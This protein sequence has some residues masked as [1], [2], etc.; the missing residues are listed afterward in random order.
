[1][2]TSGDF[3]IIG[4]GAI[5]K[6]L[7]RSFPHAK[8][9]IRPDFDIRDT[10][11]DMPY[12]PKG[13]AVICAAITGV[14]MC[15]AYPDWSRAVNVEAT[16]ALAEHLAS[17]G[18]RVVMLS[19]GAAINP[20]TEY[21]R[22]KEELEGLWAW[23]PI[24]RLPKIL[25]G[26]VPLIDNWIRLMRI[27]HPVYAFQYGI[28]QPL[29][30]KSVAEAI[31]VVAPQPLGIYSIAGPAVTWLTIARVLAERLGCYPEMII[32]EEKATPWIAME[33]FPMRYLG[34]EP[35]TLEEVI[36]TVIKEWKM[37]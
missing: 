5:S 21:G 9:I 36:D 15:E 27:G 18:W 7:Q 19:S 10:P 16:D 34:W 4:N 14:Q 2:N 12:T 13:T 24:L 23:G 37:E 22:Q 26:G 35:P 1:M 11:Y 6:E 29:H 32:P 31:K 8:A 20:D 33:S 25:H 28:V 17:R 3:L 30:R